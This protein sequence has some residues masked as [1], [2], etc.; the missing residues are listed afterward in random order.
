MRRTPIV[1]DLQHPITT[2]NENYVLVCDEQVTAFVNVFPVALRNRPRHGTNPLLN[3]GG[4]PL[5][6]PSA[7]ALKVHSLG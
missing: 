5:E 6:N 7:I 4:R 2:G 1:Y 3:Q